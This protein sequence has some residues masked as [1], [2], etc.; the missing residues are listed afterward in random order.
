MSSRWQIP[1]SSEDLRMMVEEASRSCDVGMGDGTVG[2][3]AFIRI[4][5]NTQWY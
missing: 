4:M 3:D 1:L 5:C 2:Q